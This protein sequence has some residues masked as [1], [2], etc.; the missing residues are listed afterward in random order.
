MTALMGPSGAGATAVLRCSVLPRCAHR[1]VVVKAQRFPPG[2]STLLDVLSGR[3]TAGTASG[4]VTYGGRVASRA[5]LRRY[6]AYVLQHEL[7]IG[8]LTVAEHLM[9]QAEMKRPLDES[10]LRKAEVVEN[11][12][13]ALGLAPCRHVKVCCISGGQA[14]RVN[15]GL[16][17]VLNPR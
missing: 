11:I 3:K 8:C 13:T 15:I 16:A 10:R 7:L 5:F 2:K 17:L 1:T 4:E 9:Y 12:L 6:T 14:K